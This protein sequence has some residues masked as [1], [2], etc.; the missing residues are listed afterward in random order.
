MGKS[1]TVMEKYCVT[2]ATFRRRDMGSLGI[3]SLASGLSPRSMRLGYTPSTK[4]DGDLR[5]KV[6]RRVSMLAVRIVFPRITKHATGKSCSRVF[7]STVPDVINVV[8]VNVMR[9][10]VLI[11]RFNKNKS[12]K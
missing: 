6:L 2:E 11:K 1:T 7:S 5:R 10:S 9:T 12:V 8:N 3:S 4:N